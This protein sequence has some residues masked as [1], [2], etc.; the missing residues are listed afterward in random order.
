L[1]ILSG[2]AALYFPSNDRL[3]AKAVSI[4]NSWSS[5]KE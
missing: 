2:L 4:L 1:L 3:P 5:P